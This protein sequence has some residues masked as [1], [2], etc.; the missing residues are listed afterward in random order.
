[1]ITPFYEAIA[2]PGNIAGGVQRPR[3]RNKAVQLL[4]LRDYSRHAGLVSL[5]VIG[6]RS[7]V[8]A[9]TL[10]VI[11]DTELLTCVHVEFD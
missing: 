1:M 5:S 6:L 7:N 4:L 9:T 11:L 2:L 10:D 3:P 8:R